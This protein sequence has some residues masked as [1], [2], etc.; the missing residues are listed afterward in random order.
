MSSESVTN[1]DPKAARVLVL[2]SEQPEH[3][4]VTLDP[5]V[6]EHTNADAAANRE[7]EGVRRGP[8]R[9]G[10]RPDRNRGNG[11]QEAQ[12]RQVCQ[13][14]DERI[15][16]V[17]RRVAH[18]RDAAAGDEV[19]IETIGGRRDVHADVVGEDDGA[20]ALIRES[21]LR[22]DG[23]KNNAARH[24]R[25]WRREN[26]N[27]RSRHA[28][29]G[30][31]PRAGEVRL[32]RRNGGGFD[33][34]PWDPVQPVFER[35]GKRPRGARLHVRLRPGAAGARTAIILPDPRP[36]VG[37]TPP[38]SSFHLS[39]AVLMVFVNPSRLTGSPACWAATVS[40]VGPP[41]AWPP[42]SMPTRV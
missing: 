26:R 36:T 24:R 33:L 31:D 18:V 21:R 41:P 28:S 17:V 15:V 34:E 20:A 14:V 7:G 1:A 39:S 3:P 42:V 2:A 37:S 25:G 27:R 30:E 11:N 32:Q 8:D 38:S 22:K 16:D 12:G 35:P 19:W 9:L 4:Q 10:D 23:R 6:R 5:Q 40:N 29:R 13:T